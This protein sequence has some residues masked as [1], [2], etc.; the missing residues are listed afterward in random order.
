MRSSK[1]VSHDAEA[2]K[3]QEGGIGSGAA[4]KAKLAS[5]GGEGDAAGAH[6]AAA[7]A[8]AASAGAAAGGVA[9]GGKEQIGGDAAARNGGGGGAAA[10]DGSLSGGKEGGEAD[11]KSD[12]LTEQPDAKVK[13]EQ[14][15][16][17]DSVKPDLVSIR[18]HTCQ[19]LNR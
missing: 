2:Q 16:T 7:A 5:E 4:K 9:T 3:P 1:R 17:A 14:A 10:P 12:S 8:S 15:T 6:A 18:L 13:A 11:V 19:L